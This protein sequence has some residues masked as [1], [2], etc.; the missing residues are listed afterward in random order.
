MK[1]QILITVFLTIAL[2]A[3]SS[4][5]KEANH[6]EASM[7]EKAEHTV[8]KAKGAA[9]KAMKKM[10]SS[11]ASCELK[12]DKRT[13]AV[14]ETASGGCEVIYSK[15]GDSTSVASGSKGSSHCEGVVTKIKENLENAGFK[16][17]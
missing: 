10:S 17:E 6:D 11:E 13:I 2:G 16:C 5:K 15:F 7:K 4:T 14:Q 12:N 9:K 3:C 8:D 1:T